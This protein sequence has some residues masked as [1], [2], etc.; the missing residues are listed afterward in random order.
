MGSIDEDTENEFEEEYESD[1]ESETHSLQQ[2]VSYTSRHKISKR[3][4]NEIDSQANDDESQLEQSKK[5]Q[6][7]TY[8]SDS[9][10]DNDER[11]GPSLL[12]GRV[13][14]KRPS[15]SITATTPV[16][17]THQTVHTHYSDSSEDEYEFN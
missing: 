9:S 7:Q 1:D 13:S 3:Q 8:Y 2:A 17:L 4:N 5:P 14:R 16:T 10:K 12:I 11:A 6:D 15:P